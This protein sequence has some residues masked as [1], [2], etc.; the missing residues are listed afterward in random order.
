MLK[1][2]GYLKPKEWLF[3]WSSLIF[4]VALVWLDLKLPEYMYEI[5]TLIQTPG[6]AAKA[7]W[8]AGGYMLLCAFGSFTGAVI[9]A[10]LAAHISSS[11]SENLRRQMF[12]RVESFSMEEIKRFS[13]SSLITRSTSDITQVQLL[14][15][16]G[17]QLVIKAPIMAIWATRKITGKGYEW[18]FAFGTVLVVMLIMVALIMIFLLPRFIRMQKL[19]D[20]I[21]SISGEPLMGLRVASDCDAGSSQEEMLEAANIELTSKQLAANQAMAILIPLMNTIMIGL[22][23]SVFWIGAHLIEKSGAAAEKIEVFSS[24]VVFSQYAMLVITAFMMPIIIL[25]MLPRAD[26]SAKRIIEVL[27][28]MPS[29]TDYIESEGL[30]GKAGEVTFNRVS[31]KYPDAVEYALE[32]VSFTAKKGET[33]AFVGSA[34]SG[35]STLVNLILR[36]FDATE[37]EVLVAGIDVREYWLKCFYNMIGYVPQKALLFK[38]TV[39]S[40]VGM[41]ANC[42]MLNKQKQ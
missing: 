37:G 32:D 4:I 13:T 42:L 8:I 36:F 34:S 20:R 2:F 15:S 1:I 10:Y 23:L 11:L 26:A 25:I 30:P 38:G 5:T 22:S 3:A 12:E 40:N 35:K 21:T 17:L 19:T 16:M 41:A 31:F 6:S 14:V 18:S 39:G 9:V 27:D 33:V 28:T 29:I 7:V 24:M